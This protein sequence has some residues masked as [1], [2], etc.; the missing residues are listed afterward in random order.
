MQRDRVLTSWYW[1]ANCRVRTAVKMVSVSVRCWPLSTWWE[2]MALWNA[3]TATLSSA[4]SSSLKTSFRCKSLKLVWLLLTFYHW[5]SS[6][7]NQPHLFHTKCNV[8]CDYNPIFS[9]GI[10]TFCFGGKVWFWPA[11]LAPK[12]CP[13]KRISYKWQ[14]SQAVEIISKFSWYAL[15][16]EQSVK[17]NYTPPFLQLAP[18]IAYL[19]F[20][21]S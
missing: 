2:M 15:L 1:F 5:K 6:K 12:H 8:A 7:A 20:K 10:F 9:L 19:R 21:F 11:F 18:P 4:S 13:K 16:N 14:A 17:L 3:M